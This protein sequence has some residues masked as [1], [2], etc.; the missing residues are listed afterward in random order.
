MSRPG[1]PPDPTLG[2]T[3]AGQAL[4][5]SCGSPGRGQRGAGRQRHGDAQQPGPKLGISRPNRD[6]SGPL[7][8]IEPYQ[9]PIRD[10]P[11]Y[12]ALLGGIY[13]YIYI[14]MYVHIYIELY[15]HLLLHLYLYVYTYTYGGRNLSHGSYELQL[16]LTIS[17]AGAILR[18]ERGFRYSNYSI[19]SLQSLRRVALEPGEIL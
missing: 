8:P 13:I 3:W 10:Y 15:I 14:Y 19:V 18:V 6:Y 7:G 11:A 2:Q 5:N 16:Q 9:G 4:P 1:P 17:M 12:L